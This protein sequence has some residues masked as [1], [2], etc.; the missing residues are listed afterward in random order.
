MHRAAPLLSHLRR[1][2]SC[3]VF[4]HVLHSLMFRICSSDT[5]IRALYYLSLLTYQP[6]SL[7]VS[8]T[9][10]SPWHVSGLRTPGQIAS[11]FVR[12]INSRATVIHA[13]PHLCITFVHALHSLSLLMYSHVAWSLPDLFFYLTYIRPQTSR[14]DYPVMAHGF[15]I[16]RYEQMGIKYPA[17]PYGHSLV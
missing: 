17:G 11:S 3:T 9:C 10:S 2:H 12:C 7:E 6:H 14:P 15:T 8:L 5:L 16:R 4:A 1:I 13:L